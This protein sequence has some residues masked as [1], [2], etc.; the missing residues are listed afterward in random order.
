M[1][2]W[3]SDGDFS[4]RLLYRGKLV[5][6]DP[7]KHIGK[8]FQWKYF[9]QAATLKDEEI[10]SALVQEYPGGLSIG[11]LKIITFYCKV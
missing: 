2:K 4:F 10:L 11:T 1:H 6:G 8:T 5:Q 3:V 9:E 7:G